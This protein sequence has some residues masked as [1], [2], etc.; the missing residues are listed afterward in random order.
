MILIEVLISNISSISIFIPLKNI[1]FVVFIIDDYFIRCSVSLILVEFNISFLLFLFVVSLKT[2]LI[3][4]LLGLL[5]L[6]FV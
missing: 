1:F 3:R 2:L 5:P 4:V 6:G